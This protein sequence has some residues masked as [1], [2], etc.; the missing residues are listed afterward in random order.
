MGLTNFPNGISSFG[1]PVL[2][3]GSNTWST[4]GTAYFVDAVHGSDSYSGKSP[5]RAF[6]SIATAYAACT[7]GHGDVVY[8]LS[9][10]TTSSTARLSA[11]LT[12]AKNNTHLIGLGAPSMLSQRSRIAPTAA[13]TQFTPFI[14]LSGSGCLFQNVSFF[15]GFTTGVNAANVC[16]ALSGSRNAIVNCHIAGMGTA[17]AGDHAGGR[18]VEVTGSENYFG[19]STIGLDT[20]PRSAANAEIGFSG[21]SAARNMF[22]DCMILSFADNA[23]H[24]FVTAAT[25]LCMDRWQWFKNCLFMNPTDSTAS[26]MT[27]GMSTHATM[28][29]TIVIDNSFMI[30]ATDVASDFTQVK[31]LGPSANG[32]YAQGVGLGISLA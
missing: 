31:G 15:Y 17:L 18:S 20:M 2:G 32:T 3:G 27:V 29:G 28:G 4:Q 22:E 25:A 6:A 12:W 24:L 13:A 26:A 8:I 10:G 16:L 11:T 23:G 30:G 7:D 14:T 9:D 21:G 19:H 1:I 5:K